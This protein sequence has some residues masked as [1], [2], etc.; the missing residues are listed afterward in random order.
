MIQRVRTRLSGKLLELKVATLLFSVL[1]CSEIG[2]A[3]Q[4]TFSAQVELAKQ[5]GGSNLA[6]GSGLVMWLVPLGRPVSEES[7]SVA[8]PQRRPRLEQKHKA[9]IPR[10]LVVQAGSV[11]EFPNQDPF[12]HNVFSLFEGKRFDLG[13]YEAGSSRMVR[14]DRPGICYIFCNIHSEMSAVVV[15]VDT[16][17]F[18]ISDRS[19]KLTILNV[20]VGRYQLHV[21]DEGSLPEVLSGLTREIAVSGSTHSLGVLRVRSATGLSL[22]HKNKYG[23]DYVDPT[24]PNPVY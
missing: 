16:P 4:T 20:P 12:F 5:S 14:F 10:I 11:V 1:G 21:W 18:G 7:T 8:I 19:G 13:L 17:Y 24:P 22:A 6:D 15:V 3:Q 23:R 9:F 2:L